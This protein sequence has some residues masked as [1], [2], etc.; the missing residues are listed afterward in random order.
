MWTSKGPC[1]LIILDTLG[2]HD[3]GD[4]RKSSQFF[5]FATKNQGEFS[6]FQPTKNKIKLIFPPAN[7]ESDFSTDKKDYVN[8]SNQR[9]EMLMVEK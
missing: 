6:I 3:D 9:V 5:Q 7:I 4:I 2:S 1:N 8:F